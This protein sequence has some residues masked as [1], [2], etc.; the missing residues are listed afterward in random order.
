MHKAWKIERG[1][2]CRLKYFSC[3]G[4]PPFGG[5]YVLVKELGQKDLKENFSHKDLDE[6][7]LVQK[8]LK[9]SARRP[10]KRTRPT[11]PSRARP[12]NPRRSRSCRPW[13]KQNWAAGGPKLAEGLSNNVLDPGRSPGHKDQ[14]S[15]SPSRH[16]GSRYHWWTCS[17]SSKMFW[18]EAQE[19]YVIGPVWHRMWWNPHVRIKCCKLFH[20]GIHPPKQMSNMCSRSLLTHPL[21]TC[22]PKNMVITNWV[23]TSWGY[24]FNQLTWRERERVAL[25]EIKQFNILHTWINFNIH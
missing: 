2:G 24:H 23:T 4:S 7:T 8:T 6:K 11:R 17:A 18:T 20:N 25:S 12:A 5:G 9:N 10:S 3:T 15:R 1:G 19:P 21:C 22:Q 13:R 14:T 16:R